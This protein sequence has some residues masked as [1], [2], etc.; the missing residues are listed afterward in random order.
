MSFLK[1]KTSRRDESSAILRPVGPQEAYQ[2]AAHLLE[3]YFAAGMTCRYT[4][5]Q[6][7]AVEQESSSLEDVFEQA[8]ARTVLEHPL[9]QVG[10]INEDS[11]QPSFIKLACIDFRNHV[12]WQTVDGASTTQDDHLLR[13]LHEQHDKPFERLDQQPLW[14]VVLL[15]DS[16][17]GFID[18]FF[19]WNH[20]MADAMSAKIF[21]QT[22]Q[23]ELR[24]SASDRPSIPLEDHILQLPEAIK[25]SPTLA[26]LMNLQLSA[27]FVVSELWKDMR[28]AFM[29]TEADYKANWA[30]IKRKPNKT[31]IQLVNIA[32]D[33]LSAVLQ[34]CKQN[35]TT[36]TALL[37][38]LV[39]AA[40]A[41][42]LSAQQA[43]AFETGIVVDMRRF[44]TSLPPGH[45]DLK[46]TRL[47]GN[48]LGYHQHK[49]TKEV[50]AKVRADC[51]NQVGQDSSSPGEATTTDDLEQDVWRICREVTEGLGEKLASGMKD[52][53]MALF[54]F[55]PDWRKYFDDAVTKPRNIAFELSNL[56]VLDGAPN[57]SKTGEPQS[58]EQDLSWTITQAIFT[59]SA[60]AHGPAYIINPIS[61]QGGS[62]IISC[63]WQDKIIEETVALGVTSDLQVWLQDLG[64]ERP[65]SVGKV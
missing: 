24:L 37:N 65:L 31:R 1:G 32:A 12:T 26:D 15:R 54:K 52:D 19:A 36:L 45:Q 2:A 14:R 58:A 42:R 7:L 51:E 48:Y 3:Q 53:M 50:V 59:Q 63:V 13:V 10:L 33:T 17:N 5:P 28:P 60:S 16:A 43:V 9:L 23:E 8:L 47:M 35:K 30:P 21:H 39:L 20:T 6:H 61:V 55:V 25:V 34:R 62:L 57:K 56:G 4:T 38:V 22:L 46:P 40:F 41:K 29:N 27:K 18:I 11:K 49:F 64:G 44:M